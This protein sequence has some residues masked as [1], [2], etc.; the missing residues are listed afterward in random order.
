M[1]PGDPVLYSTNPLLYGPMEIAHE[2]QDD[3]WKVVCIIDPDSRY[4]SFEVFDKSE[5]EVIVH[6]QAA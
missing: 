1:K 4:P 6:A 5:L 2:R 3:P